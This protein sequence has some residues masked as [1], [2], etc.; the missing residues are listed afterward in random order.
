MADAPGA[1]ASSAVGSPRPGVGEPGLGAGS[2]TRDG[3]DHAEGASRPPAID[4][5]ATLPRA[6]SSA[7]AWALAVA[8]IAF[9]RGAGLPVKGIAV[10]A[11]LAGASGPFLAVRGPIVARHVGVSVFLALD[12]VTWLLARSAIGPQRLE[13][14]RAGLGALAFGVWALSWGDVFR[15]APR[16]QGVAVEGPVLPARSRLPALAVPIAAVSVAS[17]MVVAGLAWRVADPARALAGQAVALASAV[18]LVSAGAT[19]AISREARRTPPTKLPP[20]ARR[21]LA[22]LLVVGIVG[23]VAL[24]LRAAT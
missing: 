24:A 20:D 8:P 2:A 17:A 7:L 1:D 18:A 23:V 10:L 9:S 22:L 4:S 11:L 15:A 21:S 13:P 12:V 3:R 19:I 5:A 14:L 6:L 16:S